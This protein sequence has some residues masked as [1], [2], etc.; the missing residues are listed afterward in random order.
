MPSINNKYVPIVE[1]FENSDEFSY[2]AN[3]YKENECYT[4]LLKGTYEYKLFWEEVREYCIKGFTNSKGITITGNHFFYLNFCRIVGYD[5]ATGK[6]T[7]IFPLFM[8]L[9]YDYFHMIKYCEDF[10]KCLLAVKGRR[11]GWSYKAASLCSWEFTF[12]RSSSSLI[13][14]FLSSF[15]LTTMQFAIDNLNWINANTEFRQQRNPDLKD[16]VVARFQADVGGVKVWK[17]SKSQIRTISFKDNPTAAVGKSASKLILDEAGVFPNITDTYSYT[18]P[19]IKD[20]S[21]YTGVAVVFGSS[22]NMDTGSKYFYEMFVNPSKYNMLEFDDPE[23]PQK[24]IAYFSTAARGRAGNCQNPESIWFNKPMI[25]KD[26]NSNE[27]AAIDDLMFERSKAKGGLDPKALHGQITQFPLTW[28]EAFLRDK[29]A[30]FAS[31]EMLEWLAKLETT[32]SLRDSIEVGELVFKDN[33]T[34]EFQPNLNKTYIT[35][36]PVKKEEDNTGAIAIF[37]RPETVDGQVPYSLYV[38]GCDPYDQD[39]SGVGSLGSFFI[40]KRFLKAGSTHDIIVAE[41][42]GRPQFADQF[43]ENCRRLCIYY[44]CKVLYENQLKGMKGYFEHKNSLHYM[45]EQ[46]QIIKDIVKNSTVSRGYGIHMNRGVNGSNGIKDTCE[47]YLK[48]WLYSERDDIDGKKILNLHTIKSIALLKEL[49]AY[50]IEGNYDRV[51][52]L[53]LAYLQTKELHKIH[54][55]SML[56]SINNYGN[57]KFLKKL[58]NRREAT[59]AS[60]FKFK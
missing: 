4:N 45:W 21:R 5:E 8:D 41:Y 15:G 36:F 48:D 30:I 19:L 38:A 46:P 26:G 14:T 35:S 13:G 32:K 51:I 10:N 55:D 42:T 47:I 37:E 12:F 27:E 7:E 29:G 49:I 39:K 54:V 25:D 40:Y 56:N 43:Y 6:K 22:G 59:G 52:A 23:N 18:E 50:D 57:D 3:F 24:K 58:W 1:W 31:P 33:N 44:N 9:D 53:M 2:L 34:I 17:G 20:G 60:K 28:R 11:Q 16:Q